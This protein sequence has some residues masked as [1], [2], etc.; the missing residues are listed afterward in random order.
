MPSAFEGVARSVVREL[1]R[2]GQFIPVDSLRNATRFQPYSLVGRK[3]NR[4]WSFGT[5]YECV[6]LSILDILEP[7][8]LEPAV[9]KSVSFHLQDVVDGQVQGNVE[10]GGPG[11]G[12]L[13]GGAAMSNS[14]STSMDVCTLR[15]ETS[16]WEALQQERH[17]RQPE[18]M[19]LKQLRRRGD[20]VYVVTEVLQTQKDVEVTRTRKREGSGQ[21][22]LPGAECVQG[23]G[24][25]HSS[26]KTTVTIPSGSVLA[27]QVAQ[28]VID[29][30]WRVLL[31]PDKKQQ[32]FQP[33]QD[34][35]RSGLK[36]W[37]QSSKL[38]CGF[39]LDHDGVEETMSLTKEDFEG[40]RAEVDA[41]TKQ[42]KFL[43]GKLR[44]KLL[45][46]LKRLLQDSEA[47]QD[48]EEAL[49]QGVRSG[50]SEPRQGAVGDV[51]ECLVLPSRELVYELAIPVSFLLEALTALS[52]TQHVLLVQ[53][54]E[55]QAL[56]GQL[57][58]VANILQQSSPWQETRDVSLPPELL[59]DDWVEDSPV[60]ILLEECGLELRAHPAQ[61]RWEPEAQ[62]CTCALYAALALL[63]S[64]SQAPR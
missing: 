19:V 28:L 36:S 62:G 54:L 5:R 15:V 14:S 52:E 34:E 33:I 4:S 25:G 9:K 32:T 37:F 61:V 40:L 46:D 44:Q 64:L 12:R 42:L 20:N 55:S 17:L 60:W 35:Q 11:Q 26:R 18:H 53:A 48:L 58:L 31:F 49:E 27:F 6:N 21:F 10:L 47:L 7:P 41:K 51:L 22:S 59:G 39:G 30:E 57:G 13:A 16:T 56:P 1:D 8:G 43:S 50:R 45:G 29:P 24:S 3:S 23:E 2:K 63:L 38:V